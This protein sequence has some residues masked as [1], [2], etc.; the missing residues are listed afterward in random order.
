MTIDDLFDYIN[1]RS[2]GGNL[3]IA[4][5][6]RSVNCKEWEEE[7]KYLEKAMDRSLPMAT[8][9]YIKIK[10][11]R[12][13][14]SEGHYHEGHIDFRSI[15]VSISDAFLPIPN[16]KSFF[17]TCRKSYKSD[18]IFNP[19]ILTVPYATPTNEITSCSPASIWIV[20]TTLSNEFGKEYLS[21]ISIN[22]ALSATVGSAVG[23]KE[24]NKL[25][26]KFSYSAH[27][28]LGKKKKEL[29][30]N[31][32]KQISQCKDEGKD[33]II[34]N[35]YW[36]F[37]DIEGDLS[38]TIMDAEVLY[39]YIESEIPIYLV[40]KWNDLREELKYGGPSED[41]HSV[42]AIGHTLNE[43]GT[44]SNFVIHDVSCAPFLEIS[45]KMIDENLVEA[46]VILPED[47]KMRYE[48]T[49]NLI[50]K[51][52]KMYNVLFDN[53]F[54][55]GLKWTF[56]PFLMRSQRIKFWYTHKKYPPAVRNMYSQADFPKYV[57]VFEIGTPELKENNRCIGQI[58]IDA[59]KPEDSMG[60]VLMNLPKYRLWYQD[61][62]L[63][64][65]SLEIPTFKDLPLFKDPAFAL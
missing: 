5:K 57:W 61:S 45:K 10:D 65:E 29:Y 18:D 6:I 58:I 52:I 62:V 56:R 46:L 28:Y 11:E 33:C 30:E 27:F 15:S 9:Y 47:V 3:Q 51:I 24:Y 37:R 13:K 22:N 19:T 23:I 64:E 35:F 34:S 20:L 39:A 7:R 2:Y 1:E 48:H 55:A 54:K 32:E 40:F 14:G 42:V 36:V 60:L 8:R 17:I 50:L 12:N 16:H 4:D 43:K 49:Q 26:L 59:T 53:I 63:M 41:Y 21:L 25:F 38:E 44:V 31:C